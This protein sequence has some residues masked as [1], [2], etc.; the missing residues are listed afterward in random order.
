MYA[1]GMMTTA[2]VSIITVRPT[3][4]PYKTVQ[5]GKHSKLFYYLDLFSH[6]LLHSSTCLYFLH[7]VV[8]IG[9]VWLCRML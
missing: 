3:M 1:I 2:L 4:E 7:G 9:H 6:C 8:M 5:N